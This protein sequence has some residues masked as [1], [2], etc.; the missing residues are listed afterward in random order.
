[1]MSIARRKEPAMAHPVNMSDL[2]RQIDQE[3]EAEAGV[4]ATLAAYAPP[5]VR[6]AVPNEE[7]VVRHITKFAELPTK[8]IDE[9]V[10]AAK[11]EIEALEAYAQK[12]RDLYVTATD[13]INSD[14]KRLREGVRLSMETMQQLRDHCSAL[15]EEPK[16]PKNGEMKQ[17]M[18]SDDPDV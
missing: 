6:N 16:L 3:Q 9:V 18:P 8:E 10:K 4:A 12:V 14:I 5:E 11:E 15:N 1:M 13:R 7:P 2:A 17:H